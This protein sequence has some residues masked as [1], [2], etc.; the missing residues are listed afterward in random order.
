MNN[1]FEK[2]IA[3]FVGV[4]FSNHIIYNIVE[5]EGEFELTGLSI[6][7]YL[8]SDKNKFMADIMLGQSHDCIKLLLDDHMEYG[9]YQDD[10]NTNIITFNKLYNLMSTHEEIEY[11]YVFDVLE[12]LLF[13]KT[14]ELIEPI[15]IDYKNSQDVR[16][17]RNKIK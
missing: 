12:N 7:N 10:Q 1:G 9:E 11:Y 14:P 15:A 8:N 6:I 2:E 5:E 3:A 17:F 13:V 16:N 4:S